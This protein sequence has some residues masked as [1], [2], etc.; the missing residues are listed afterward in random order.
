MASSPSFRRQ[1]R[2]QEQIR[3]LASRRS[4]NTDGLRN[5]R[6]TYACQECQDKGILGTQGNGELLFCTCAEATA[7]RKRE[8]ALLE[9]QRRW[10]AEQEAERVVLLRESTY[11]RLADFSTR[12]KKSLMSLD[13]YPVAEEGIP[14]LNFLKGFR[15]HWD[16]STG[17]ILSGGYGLGKTTLQLAMLHD[18]A[19]K[20]VARKMSVRLVNSLEFVRQLQ[21]GYEKN[22]P[23]GQTYDIVLE[24]YQT[25]GVLFFDD[26]GAE[27]M[28]E[29][30]DQ[31]FKLLIDWR[32]D[33]GLPIFMTTNLTSTEMK[34]HLDPR[35]FERLREMCDIIQVKGTNYRD[36]HI[37]ARAAQRKGWD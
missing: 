17:L 1:A 32:Y 25:C 35:L 10:V 27:R 7:A 3:E 12:A 5:E 37:A 18:L 28:T 6:R 21:A 2:V 13:T 31:Q 11:K 33:K 29:W 23:D 9:Q 22:A 34:Q 36:Q 16:F 14:T 15:D 20:L 24:N 26:L 19:E 8:A 4:V 30:V